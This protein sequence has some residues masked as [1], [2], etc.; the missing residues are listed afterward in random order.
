MPERDVVVEILGKKYLVKCAT[1]EVAHL[2]QAAIFVAK[3]MQRVRDGGKIIGSDRVAV[4][5]A[6]NI[7]HILFT[8]EKREDTAIK[9]MIRRADAWSRRIEDL[10]DP[11][12]NYEL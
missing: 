11:A 7:A 9:Q 8:A 12:E 2:Q 10:L 4:I 5:T 3:E 1:D 6:L